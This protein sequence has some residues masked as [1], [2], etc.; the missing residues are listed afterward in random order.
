MA[1][2]P[3]APVVWDSSNTNVAEP[4]AGKK[5]AGFANGEPF[6]SSWANWFFQQLG[7]FTAWF[8]QEIGAGLTT[9]ARSWV[10]QTFDAGAANAN[11]GV[12][13]QGGSSNGPGILATGGGS[14]GIGV[15]GMGSGGGAGGRFQAGTTA[16]ASA[17]ADAIVA[18]NGDFDM[19]GVANPDSNV[20]FIKRLTPQNMCK[21]WA[22]VSVT[23]GNGTGNY[24]VSVLDGFNITSVSRPTGTGHDGEYV[25]VTFGGDF[26][27]THYCAEGTFHRVGA[28]P[29]MGIL[30]VDS[31]VLAT[32]QMDFAIFDPTTG[33]NVNFDALSTGTSNRIHL[34]IFGRQ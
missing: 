25:R 14:V 22:T 18:A 8:D 32:G 21:A 28:A 15:K 19:S 7:L 10:N 12:T 5:T 30:Y 11:P 2:R 9:V 6:P 31:A 29:I 24:S 33:L 1:T 17:R 23:P 26:A 4:S 20:S 16:T 13:A 27:D 3:S 34:Q